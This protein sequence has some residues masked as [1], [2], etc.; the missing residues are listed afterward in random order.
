M[1][2]SADFTSRNDSD[3]SISADENASYR[4]LIGG[5]IYAAICT[6]PDISFAAGVLARQVHKPCHRHYVLTKRLVRYL[7]GTS[8]LAL[9]YSR[10]AGDLYEPLTEY[11][12]SE[13]AG[14]E[15]TRKSTTGVLVTINNAPIFWTSK[16]QS[17]MCLSSAE[18]EYVVAS[19]CAEQITSLHRLYYDLCNLKPSI[20]EPQFS[21]TT[22]RIDNTAAI[23][24]ATNPS[25]SERNKHCAICTL[26]IRDLIPQQKVRLYHI[27]SDEQLADILT[28]PLPRVDCLVMIKR[29][30]MLPAA[31]Y[32]SVY[33]R[34]FRCSVFRIFLRVLTNL[35]R[36]PCF[37]PQG[38]TRLWFYWWSDSFSVTNI[39]QWRSRM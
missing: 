6:S 15:D 10:S 24:I 31:W 33:L 9:L 27:P 21:P 11:C 34:R 8:F 37:F 17:I 7:T 25:V 29:L 39:L 22:M 3:E 4:S 19:H 38:F 2:S 18:A 20:D 26:H 1:S 13:W 16:R 35:F 5:V 12:D 36:R 32:Y 28:K 30:M 23:S 14:C